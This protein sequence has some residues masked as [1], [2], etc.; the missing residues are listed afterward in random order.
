MTLILDMRLHSMYFNSPYGAVVTHLTCNE[1]IRG[2]N[3]RAGLVEIRRF[4]CSIYALGTRYVPRADTVSN[5][6]AEAKAVPL[7]QTKFA[8]KDGSTSEVRRHMFLAS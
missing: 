5:H 3:P 1:K 2:S 7:R 6:E 4:R 8:S